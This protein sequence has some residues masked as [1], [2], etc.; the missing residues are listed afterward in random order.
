MHGGVFTAKSS[1]YGGFSMK[2]YKVVPYTG[3]LVIN[4]K[5]VVQ[6]KIVEYF[7]VINQECVDGWEFLTM[8]PVNVAVKEGGL[9]AKN[10]TYNAFV[11][12]K[13]VEEE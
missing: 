6:N 10:E 13:E 7:D 1:L 5:D 9:K 2:T 11:F 3:T 8:A 12:V 4:K